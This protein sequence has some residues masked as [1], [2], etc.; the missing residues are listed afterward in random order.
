MARSFH[1]PFIECSAA[2]GVNVDVAFRELVKLVRKDKMVGLY[3]RCMR[4]CTNSSAHGTRRAKDPQWTS[5]LA[6]VSGS[7]THQR[8]AFGRQ[9]E[10]DAVYDHVRQYI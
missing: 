9:D 4:L 8:G 2:D 1:A 5:C 6:T 3:S 7:T 10:E